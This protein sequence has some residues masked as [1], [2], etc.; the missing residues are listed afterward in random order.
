MILIIINNM[1]QGMILIIIKIMNLIINNIIKD[2]LIIQILIITD[3][4]NFL[5][6]L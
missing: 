5:K 6:I 3:I 2:N 1:I 4:T